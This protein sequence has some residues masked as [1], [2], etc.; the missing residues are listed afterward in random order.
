MMFT[1]VCFDV[2]G[3]RTCF[4]CKKSSDDMVQCSVLSCHRYYHTECLRR[5]G[6][7]GRKDSGRNVCSRHFCA[8]CLTRFPVKSSAATSLGSVSFPFMFA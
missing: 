2:I 3:I 5:L 7:T 1:V 8:T 6:V 4:E